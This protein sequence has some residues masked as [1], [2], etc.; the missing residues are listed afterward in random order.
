MKEDVPFDKAGQKDLKG[1]RPF[2]AGCQHMGNPVQ[3]RNKDTGDGNLDKGT[4]FE[5]FLLSPCLQRI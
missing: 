2:D 4:G 1:F 3:Q 5:R